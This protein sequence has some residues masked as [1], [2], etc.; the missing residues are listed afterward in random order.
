MTTWVVAKLAD[1]E[2]NGISSALKRAGRGVEF[3]DTCEE[4]RIRLENDDAPFG[5]LVSTGLSGCAE[6]LDWIRGEGRLFSLPIL[7]MAGAPTDQAFGD[8]HAMG[9]DDVF[10]RGDD[11]AVTRRLANL[12]GLDLNVRPPVTQGKS[13]IVQPDD[14]RRRVLG[15]ILRQAGFDPMFADGEEAFRTACSPEE[16]PALCVVSDQIE[17]ESLARG[18]LALRDQGPQ[19]VMPVIILGTVT[20]ALHERAREIGPAAVVDGDAPA[21]NLLFVANELLRTDLTNLRAS[22]R[23]LYGTICA[24]RAAGDLHPVFGLTYNLSREGL[25]VRTLDP[26]SAGSLIWFEMRPLGSNSAV[27]LRAEVT[28][29]RGL[30]SPGGATPPGFGMKL[31]PQACPPGDLA[32][33]HD[34]YEELRNTH[35]IFTSRTEA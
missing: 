11:G 26:P 18:V 7:G 28:W 6:M 13:L 2:K 9:V 21:D 22:N 1:H 34:A 27:H 19:E 3:F 20:G 23:I 31:L 16:R 14:S 32:E 30:H 10:V 12:T 8:A 24:F 17:Q 25:F 4:A 33:Y 35:N 5:L 29:C 15:R